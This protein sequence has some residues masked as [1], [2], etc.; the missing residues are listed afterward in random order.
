MKGKDARF[1]KHEILST[2]NPFEELNIPKLAED[3]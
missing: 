2:L 3:D 1:N